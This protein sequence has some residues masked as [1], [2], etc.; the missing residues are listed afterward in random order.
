MM[1][2]VVLDVRSKDVL[3]AE[4]VDAKVRTLGNWSNRL[5]GSW[6][7]ESDALGA[8]GIR[9]AIRGE[10]NDTDRLFVARISRNWAGRNMGKGFPEWMKRRE[11]GDFPKG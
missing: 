10:L 5:N 8:G 6:L 2:L 7:L 1:F 11:F 4:K 9:D 3:V